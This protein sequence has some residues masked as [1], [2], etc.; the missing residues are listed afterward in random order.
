MFDPELLMPL[1]EFRGKVGELVA[2]IEGSEPV[3]GGAKVR[4]PGRASLARR[5][6]AHERGTIEVDDQIFAE[7]IR[8]R[9][10]ARAAARR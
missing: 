9:D 10:Y 2:H 6:A 4:V 5:A 3:P 8:I 1:E 7:L